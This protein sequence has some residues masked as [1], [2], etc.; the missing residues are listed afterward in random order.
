MN[1]EEAISDQ[2][3]R[4]VA[5]DTA[6]HPLYMHPSQMARP[7]AMVASQAV[8]MAQPSDIEKPFV[9]DAT[10]VKHDRSHQLYP[11]LNLS[12]GEYVVAVVRRHPIGLFVAF[13]LGLL[14]VTIA[15]SALFNYDIVVQI[16]RLKGAAANVGSMA[17]P[18]IALVLLICLLTYVAYYVY[19]NNKFY[20]TNE[21]IIEQTQTSLFSHV[22]KSI[23]LASVEDIS[24]AQTN[25]LQALV[26]YGTIKLS[27][28]GDE[29]SYLYNYV[30][31]PKDYVDTLNNAVEAAKNGHTAAL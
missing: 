31:S 13:G 12:E 17:L 10:K 28:I 29:K 25:V 9:S 20:L 3:E 27:T 8:H 15:I 11:T 6:G 14:F 4:P 26:N 16:L 18:I 1:P 22:E 30:A 24:Y 5:Y 19:I 23:D 7:E 21:S 2:D